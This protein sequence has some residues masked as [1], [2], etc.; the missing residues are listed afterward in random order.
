MF[1][2]SYHY[3]NHDVTT[4]LDYQVLVE[5]TATVV[6]MFANRRLHLL[7]E[8]AEL[9]VVSRQFRQ[10]C[11]LRG[12]RKEERAHARPSRGHEFLETLEDLVPV[13]LSVHSHLFQ[14]VVTH[15]H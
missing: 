7:F 12:S 9:R 14:L 1:I 8:L 5:D 10:H 6:F 11:A 3:Y 4:D 13:T 15:L 2:A